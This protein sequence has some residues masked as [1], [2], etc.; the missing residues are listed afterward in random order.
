MIQAWQ[1]FVS[2]LAAI[3]ITLSGG[4][5]PDSMADLASTQWVDE[6][7]WVYSFNEDASLFACYETVFIYGRMSTGEYRQAAIT[8]NAELIYYLDYR[9]FDFS[10]DGADLLLH[11][12]H[13]QELVHSQRFTPYM[14]DNE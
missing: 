9:S 8:Q 11:C 5:Q 13:D 2:M 10:L 3:I 14:P 6:D 4:A 12:Y 1:S 7:G